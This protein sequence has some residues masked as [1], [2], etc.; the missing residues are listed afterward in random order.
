MRSLGENVSE[1]LEYI[2]ERY[3]V[4]RHLRPKLSCTRC[5]KIVQAPAASRP[6]ARGI[7]GPGML[8]MFWCLNSRIIFRSTDKA[9]FMRAR[10]SNSIARRW[11]TGSV[12]L[13]RF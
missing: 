13:T 12:E 7:A 11:Q 1:M 4:I 3:K 9:R 10:A 8:G 5:Q 6:I 2:P